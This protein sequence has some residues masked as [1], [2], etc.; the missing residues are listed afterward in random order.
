MAFLT[1]LY[2]MAAGPF[3][4][5]ICCGAYGIWP[6]PPSYRY[7][8]HCYNTSDKISPRARKTRT[9]CF[10]GTKPNGPLLF[11]SFHSSQRAQMTGTFLSYPPFVHIRTIG[12]IREGIFREGTRVSCGVR[13]VRGGERF[14]RVGKPCL[15]GKGGGM[16]GLGWVVVWKS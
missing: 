16:E 13:K 14:G 8:T 5:S 15:T 2:R 10:E 11:Y 6:T 7:A 4:H 3:H 12:R 9:P 1:L